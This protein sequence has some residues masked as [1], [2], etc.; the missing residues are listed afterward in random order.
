MSAPAAHLAAGLLLDVGVKATVLAGAALLADRVV[1]ASAARQHAGHA[2]VMGALVALPV[3]A[4]LGRGQALA[5]EHGWLAPVWLVGVVVALTPPIVGR[6][7]LERVARRGL[8]EGDVVR[9]LPGEV[10][11]PLTFGWWRPRVVVPWEWPQWEAADQRAALAHERAH[12]ARRDWSVHVA[13]QVVCALFWFHPLVW[14]VRAR[15][16]DAAE[17]AADDAALATGIRPSAYATALLRLGRARP[18]LAGLSAGGSVEARIR[19]VLADRARARS[20]RIVLAIGVLA[21]PA[22]LSGLGSW[23]LWSPPSAPPAC[24]PDPGLLP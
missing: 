17:R 3:F 8:V 24:Q 6:L 22:A 13:A 18:A 21:L 16:A 10:P 2:L 1:V 19:A 9:A 12:V 14:L 15:L 7:W 23:S 11:G 4:W 20:P 5:I